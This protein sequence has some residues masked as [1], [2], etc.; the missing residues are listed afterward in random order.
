MADTD[1]KTPE[2]GAENQ[3]LENKSVN[4]EAP[5]TSAELEAAKKAADQA[6]M[7]ANQLENQVKELTSKLTAVETEKLQEKEDYKSLWEQSQSKLNDIVEREEK[8]AFQAEVSKKQDEVTSGY[9]EKV[10]EIAKTAGVTLGGVDE[11]DVTAFTAK[12]DGIKQQVADDSVNTPENHP[13]SQQTDADKAQALERLRA[14][15]KTAVN[16]VVG[17]LGFIKAYRKQSEQ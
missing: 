12:L 2:T 14:G 16:D 1:V 13:I 17:S 9:S 8:L 15:D 6:T 10:L 5:Q 11:D 4:N 7:R 3:P